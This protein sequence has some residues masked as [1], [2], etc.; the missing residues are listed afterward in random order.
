MINIIR[1]G[2]KIYRVT[3]LSCGCIF[4]FTDDDIYAAQS[5]N[6]NYFQVKC[7][8][9]HKFINAWNKEEWLKK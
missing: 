4:E 8:D 1:H 6:G 9:C 3:C 7:P 5:S 2:Y